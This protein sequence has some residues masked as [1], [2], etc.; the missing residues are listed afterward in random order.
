M[1]SN[2]TEKTWKKETNFK[3]N[4][5]IFI[6]TNGNPPLKSPF[7][8]TPKQK[9]KIFWKYFLECITHKL[10]KREI[11]KNIKNP[12]IRKGKPSWKPHNMP[13]ASTDAW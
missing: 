2:E 9:T 6:F 8:I 5:E 11:F 12:K 1:L 7:R 13:K 10:A 3:K 4:N